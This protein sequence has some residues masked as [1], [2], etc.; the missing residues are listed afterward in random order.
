MVYIIKYH[1]NFQTCFH[2]C[3][4]YWVRNLTNLSDHH[5]F[6]SITFS[7][8]FLFEKVSNLSMGGMNK[9]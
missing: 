1:Y 6:S 9:R 2:T 8:R 7:K 4:F 3:H 5:E